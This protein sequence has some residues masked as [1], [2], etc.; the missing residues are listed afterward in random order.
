MKWARGYKLDLTILDIE[1]LVL[2][3]LAWAQEVA[4]NEMIGGQKANKSAMRA[5]GNTILFLSFQ[6]T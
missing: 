1:F 2:S 3:A 6:P 4:S 5:S